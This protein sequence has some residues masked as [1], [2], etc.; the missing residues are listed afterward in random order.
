MN[1]SYLHPEI[2]AFIK[3]KGLKDYVIARNRYE[4][5]TIISKQKKV[6]FKFVL[7]R[8]DLTR[9][10]QL[11]KK[12]LL[13]LEDALIAGPKIL[14]SISLKSY[15]LIAYKLIEGEVNPNKVNLIRIAQLAKLHSRIHKQLA[16]LKRPKKLTWDAKVILKPFFNPQNSFKTN[17]QEYARK[18][19]IQFKEKSN[20]I[21]SFIHSDSHFSNIVFQKNRAVLI[22]Y[23][24][25]GFASIYFE[26]AV[27]IHA[28]LYQKESQQK[29]FIRAYVRSYFGKRP[30]N[31]DEVVLLE[32]YIK[33]R[34]LE[35]ATWHL[36]ESPEDQKMNKKEN[37]LWI[38]SCFQ[39]AKEFNLKKY[40]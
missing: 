21:I 15:N 8:P 33:L 31:P 38:E 7:K 30:L 39:K 14:Q 25:A 28:L 9:K 23:A 6:V 1:K 24:E 10:L 26:I 2:L 20:D 3:K 11:E 13:R 29:G 35:A 40:L 22:D 12:N 18:L 16:P 36:L 37:K 19:E 4:A 32:N 17:H 27:V 5:I 34:F